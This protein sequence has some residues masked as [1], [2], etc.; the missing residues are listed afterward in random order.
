M[1]SKERTKLD[2][3]ISATIGE[4]PKHSGRE[5]SPDRNNQS[6]GVQI[7]LQTTKIPRIRTKDA[8]EADWIHGL[9]LADDCCW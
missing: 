7:N 6:A 4:R 5:V 8:V 3:Q 9:A 1:E 2:R